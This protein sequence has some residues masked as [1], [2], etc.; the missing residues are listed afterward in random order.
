M[1]IVQQMVVERLDKINGL[2]EQGLI[3]QRDY[4]R[5]MLWLLDCLLMLVIEEPW[6]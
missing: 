4:D 6:D 1:N 3:Y 2:M 5:T